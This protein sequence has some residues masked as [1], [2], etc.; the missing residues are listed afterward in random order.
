MTTT[1]V[2]RAPGVP[3]ASPV[4]LPR[5]RRRLADHAPFLVALLLGVGLRVVVAVAFPGAVMVSDAPGYLTFL[6]D[7]SPSVERPDGYGLLLLWPL[8]RVADSLAL[9]TTVQHVLGL[10]VAT[11][12]YAVLRRWGVGRWWAAVA[13]LPLLLDAMVLLLEHTTLSDALFLD[14]VVLAV[15]LLGW[16]ARP[17]PGVALAAGLVM[18]L[19]TVV[20][21]V[22]TP[23][24]LAG[25]LFCLLAAAGRWRRVVPALLLVVGF[26][27]PVGAYASWYH[28]TYGT[29]A[30]SGIGGTSAY[31]RTTTFVECDRLDLEPYARVL[32]P[33]EPV[34]ERRD[35]TD[36]GWYQIGEG[37]QSLAVPPGVDREEVLRD[38]ARQALAAQ[39]LDY[40]GVVLRDSVLGFDPV[41]VDRYEYNTTFK[42]RFA[43]YLDPASSPWTRMG[44]ARY[45]GA[46][47]APVQ[48]WADLLVD[49]QRVGYTPGPLV[50]LGLLLG[51]V[52]AA[53]RRSGAA[54]PYVLLLVLV[55][56][57]LS[58]L[59][60]ITTEFI[61]R[62]QLPGVL[63]LPAA[64][65][66]GLSALRRRGAGPPT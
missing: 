30:L 66:L 35:P 56:L 24:V 1:G 23:L 44:W 20:R 62:Y 7:V 5:R 41:R 21:Q 34:G 58:L 50:L 40:A 54:R 27:V 31:M 19:A 2:R 36:Y 12:L 48:P 32:C 10:A 6:D 38:F 13:A 42:W 18:G 3:G 37:A 29:Y 39:P 4:D 47:P 57:G 43:N 59:P 9:F 25:A 65:V 28:G 45:G 64:G 26:L 63:L 60:A 61:W 8:S 16:R 53:S 14:L 11:A 46:P 49:Y 17:S 15:V 52:G 55:G 51:V 22:G 33:R